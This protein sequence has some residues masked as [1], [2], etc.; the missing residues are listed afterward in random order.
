MGD[1]YLGPDEMPETD[2]EVDELLDPD[3]GFDEGGEE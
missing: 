3:D 1:R 2:E